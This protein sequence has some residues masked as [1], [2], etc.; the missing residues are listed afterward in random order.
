ML[1][2][3]SIFLLCL[4]L[5]GCTAEPE[6]AVQKPQTTDPLLV[7]YD[8]PEIGKR[9]SLPHI[10]EDISI[11]DWTREILAAESADRKDLYEF[12]QLM[13]RALT[14]PRNSR[15]F[16]DTVDLKTNISFFPA[17]IYQALD[18]QIAG[19]YKALLAQQFRQ[20]YPEGSDVLYE[21]VDSKYMQSGRREGLMIKYKLAPADEEPM[22]ITQYVLD[23]GRRNTIMHVVS[24]EAK[25]DYLSVATSLKDLR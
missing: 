16:L 14:L 24:P 8:L 1:K 12:Q 22:Y 9:V 7:P 13:N 25:R 15:V 5:V 18:A 4:L 17:P 23:D 6:P 3:P 21:E 11:D 2:F 19:Q 10:F 20:R